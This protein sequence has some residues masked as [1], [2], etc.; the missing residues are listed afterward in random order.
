VP[1]GDNDLARFKRKWGAEPVRLH[2]YHY[3]GSRDLDGVSVE[4]GGYPQLISRALWRR[5]PL[6][7]TA[8][9]GDRIYAYL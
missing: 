5:L 3:P 6:A 8:W 1:E 9:L 2:R 4:S 7:A